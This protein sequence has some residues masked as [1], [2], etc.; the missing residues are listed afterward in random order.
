MRRFLIIQTAFLGDV[1]LTLPLVQIL[2]E[3]V[4]DSLV[5]FIAIPETS[6]IVKNHP[7]ISDVIVYDKHGKQKSI[8]SFLR[9]R[10]RLRAA[11][12]DAVLCPHRSLRSCLLVRATQAKIRVGFDKAALKSAFTDVMPW[13]FGVHEIDRNRSLLNRLLADGPSTSGFS[14]ELPKIFIPDEYRLKAERFLSEHNVGQPYAVVAPGTIWETKR[15]PV[16]MMVEIVRKLSNRF[17]NIVVVGGKKDMNLIK[18]FDSLDDKVVLAIGNL[19]IMSSAE[20]IKGSSLLIAN[21][22][23]PVHIAS[24]FGVPAVAVF[25]PTIRDFGFFPYHERSKVVEVD[26]LGCRPCSIHGGHNCPISTFDCMRKISPD[27]I[28]AAASELLWE[29]KNG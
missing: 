17:D 22:S 21:D 24:A 16:D 6:D 25:G 18:N 23:A 12:Y 20:I 3:S 13:K 8:L 29:L 14:H 10:N 1:I 9:F 26:G 11:H 5:D 27:K 2:K 19:P 28:I 7:D 4:P 15:Y